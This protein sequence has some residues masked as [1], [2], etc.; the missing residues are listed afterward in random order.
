[1]L[2]IQQTRMQYT[3]KEYTTNVKKGQTIKT[4][5]ANKVEHTSTVKMNH[6]T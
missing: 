2:V 3:Q 6:V 5:R 1:M 4:I